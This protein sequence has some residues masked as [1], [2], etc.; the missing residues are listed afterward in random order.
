[1]THGELETLLKELMALPAETEWLECIFHLFDRW[2]V[3]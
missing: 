3:S 2:V 1:M